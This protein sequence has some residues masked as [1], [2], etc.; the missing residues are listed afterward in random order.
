MQENANPNFFLIW[1]QAFNLPNELL[2]ICEYYVN[3]MNSLNNNSI[4]AV[5]PIVP[6]LNHST[7]K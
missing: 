2:L 1:H 4:H 3:C 7:N 6:E 5:F